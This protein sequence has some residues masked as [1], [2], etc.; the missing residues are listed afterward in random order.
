MTKNPIPKE[1]FLEIIQ[2]FRDCPIAVYGDL[3]ADE[4]VYGEISRVSREAPVLILS[5][6]ESFIVPGGAANAINNLNA[7]GARPVPLGILGI[8]EAGKALRR[9]FSRSRV[10]LSRIRPVKGYM[11]PTKSR[12]SAGSAHSARQQV[13]RIDRG[14]GIGLDRIR[15]HRRRLDGIGFDRIGLHRKRIHGV[16]GRRD[17]RGAA[18]EALE[19]LGLEHVGGAGAAAQ[20]YDEGDGHLHAGA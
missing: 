10:P 2:Q 6:R 9:Q 14:C 5:Y 12:Y 8:D 17:H 7:L 18:E 1:R 4:F 13:L 19:E 20:E 3:V 11:T 16:G 15:L